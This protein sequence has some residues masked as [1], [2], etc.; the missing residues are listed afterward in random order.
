MTRNAKTIALALALGLCLLLTGCYV[1]PDDVNN[2]GETNAGSNLPFLTLAPNTAEP[3]TPDTVAVETPGQQGQNIFPG[4]NTATATPAPG[5]NTWN[6]WN[7]TDNPAGPSTPT[8]VPINGT[9]VFNNDT[10]VPGA[11]NTI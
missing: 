4:G 8:S 6:N 10:T 11:E 2:G 7:S 9:I 3:A 5:G 1:A